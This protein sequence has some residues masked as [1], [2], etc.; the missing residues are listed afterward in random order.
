MAKEFDVKSRF[1][2]TQ[3]VSLAYRQGQAQPALAAAQ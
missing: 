2:T 3:P 1:E